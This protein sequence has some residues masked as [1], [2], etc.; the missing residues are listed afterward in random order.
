MRTPGPEMQLD[1]PGFSL[2]K[3]LEQK[4]CPDAARERTAVLQLRGACH[5]PRFERRAAEEFYGVNDRVTAQPDP[6]A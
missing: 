4:T 5:L 3:V 2:P 6:R 1:Q